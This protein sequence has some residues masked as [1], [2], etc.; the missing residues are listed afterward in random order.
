MSAA[1]SRSRCTLCR[2]R[3]RTRTTR[4][5]HSTSRH[6]C[7]R[8]SGAVAG[9]NA[10]PTLT[11]SVCME[12]MQ[13]GWSSREPVL[14]GKITCTWLMPLLH[15]PIVG[16]PESATLSGICNQRHRPAPDEFA[17]TLAG[18]DPSRDF[19]VA[20]AQRSIAATDMSASA[21]VVPF[22]DRDPHRGHA[23]PRRPPR[24]SSAVG[25]DRRDHGPC[26]GVGVARPV[27]R[28]G[29]GLV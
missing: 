7:L 5:S 29:R 26:E 23:V 2:W 28:T 4:N 12:S 13:A 24:A 20:V 11:W 21:S 18:G 19:A 3:R 14:R 1:A 25:L 6:C 10:V 22:G 8:L 15:P 17:G 27:A 9:W 16:G